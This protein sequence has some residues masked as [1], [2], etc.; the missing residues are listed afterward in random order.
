MLYE[1]ITKIGVDN[2]FDI[3]S[4]G[5]Q[6]RLSCHYEI[7]DGIGKSQ[8]FIVVHLFYKKVGCF[9]MGLFISH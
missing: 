5:R 8:L 4:M 3:L 2:L 6:N 9:I 7:D 1:V